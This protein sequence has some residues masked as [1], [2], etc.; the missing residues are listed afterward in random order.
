MSRKQVLADMEALMDTYCTGCFLKRQNKKDHG[1]RYA[2]RFCI[3][4]CTVGEK[5]KACGTKL[6]VQNTK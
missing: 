6:S 4:Q 2:H 1:K 5:L 3:S